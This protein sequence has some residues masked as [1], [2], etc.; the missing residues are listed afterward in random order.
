[1]LRGT[2]AMKAER[3]ATRLGVE[4]L[5]DLTPTRGLQFAYGRVLN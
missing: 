2:T 4:K 1:M 5:I 3:E